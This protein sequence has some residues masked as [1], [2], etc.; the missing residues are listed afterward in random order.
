ME[1][2]E[3]SARFRRE[4]HRRTKHDSHFS[5]WQVLIGPCDW[6]DYAQGKEGAARYRVHNLPS[7]SAPGLYELGVAVSRSGLWRE[8]AG[9]LDPDDIAVVYL[10]QADNVRTRLQSYGRSGAHLAVSY[11][12]GHRSGCKSESPENAVGLFEEIFSKGHSIVYRWA[13]M[14][15]KRAAEK[16]EAQLLNT[17]DYAWNKGS[18]GVRRPN[19]II[20]KLA[21]ISSNSSKFSKISQ[22]FQFLRPGQVGIKIEA[23]N[24]QEHSND[25]EVKSNFLNR[26]LKFT[27]LQPRLVL[28]ENLGTNQNPSQICG[29][30]TSQGTPCEKPP[31][32]GRRRCKEH[33]GMRIYVLRTKKVELFEENSG[34]EIFDSNTNSNS[35][36]KCGVNLGDGIFCE[37]EAVLGRKRCEGHKGM[38]VKRSDYK[39]VLEEEHLPLNTMK[40]GVRFEDG[41]VCDKIPVRGR[42]R[43]E[44]HKGMRIKV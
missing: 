25:H 21:Q 17:F 40:C 29:I 23:A 6:D 42:K 38:R 44:E 34:F 11:D 35:S 41:I 8:F 24:P 36:T 28:S 33:K 15:D 1:S 39:P 32:S 14:K 30:I 3:I 16:T 5:K 26:I 19:D 27:K 12:G 31:V 10:G 18:N 4:D 20:Q 9:K 2:G 22:K 7:S 37:R 13:P 43:C